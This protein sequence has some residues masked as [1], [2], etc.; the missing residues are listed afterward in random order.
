[1][2]GKLSEIE[3]EEILKANT[4][5]RIGCTDATKVYIVPVNYRYE[6]NSVLCYSF[7][8]L[9]VDMMRHHPS[10]CFEVDEITNSHHW[11]C[12]IIHGVFKEITDEGELSQLKP[13]YNEYM[14]RKRARFMPLPDTQ[15]KEAPGR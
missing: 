7:E 3:I 8:G 11:K 4:I 10:V 12:V 9:K 13:H 5:G 6:T 14:L 1:M 2:L 15:G